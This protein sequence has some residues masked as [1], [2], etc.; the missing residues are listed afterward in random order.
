MTAFVERTGVE[1][2]QFKSQSDIVDEHFIFMYFRDRSEG[3]PTPLVVLGRRS[4][5]KS[6]LN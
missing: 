2:D 3:F 5:N 1:V 6:V 4:D